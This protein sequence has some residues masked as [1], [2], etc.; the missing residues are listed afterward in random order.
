MAHELNTPLATILLASNELAYVGRESKDAEVAQLASTV[1]QEAQRASDIIDLLRGRVREGT[2]SQMLDLSTVVE[3]VANEELARLR[4][5]GDIVLR[6]GEH[7][8]GWGTLAAI[9]QILANVLRNAVEAMAGLPHK[10]L[11]IVVTDSG[12]RVNVRVRD[13]GRGIASDDLQRLGEPFQTTKELAGGMGLG[14]YVCTMLAEQMG[15]RLQIESREGEETCVTLALRRGPGAA[16][17]S[18][19]ERSDAAN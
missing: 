14:L 19:E 4:F 16:G 9:R 18:S 12:D 11:E 1:A 10:R 15:A 2:S 8:R 7:V 13:T 6:V 5:D 3:E 17:G